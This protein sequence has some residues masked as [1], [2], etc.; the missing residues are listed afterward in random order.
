MMKIPAEGPTFIYSNNQSILANT[1]I[2][3]SD[4]KKKSQSL[5]YYL[6]REGVVYD[7]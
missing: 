6:V 3:E 4:L 5:A 2:S 1:F 7:K